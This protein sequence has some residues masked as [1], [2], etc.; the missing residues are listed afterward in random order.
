MHSANLRVLQFCHGY[1]GP[2]LDCARQY[3]SLFKGTPYKVTTVFLTGLADADVAAA[4]ESDEVL[5]LEQTSR[6]IRTLKLKAIREL[7]SIARTRDF[8]FCIAHRF[9]PIWIAML[10]TRMPV[11]GVHHGYGDYRRLGRKLF[12][13]LF[14]GRLRLLGV[15]N[16]VREDIRSSLPNWPAHHIE[17][18]YNRVDIEP[19]RRSQLTRQAARQALHLSPHAWIVGNAGRLH[20][21]K[22]QATLL[23]GFAHALPSLPAQAQ[24][25]ILGQ[26]RLEEALK[27]LALELGIAD[28]V[29]FL[30]QV[31]E[32]RRYFRAFDVF[33][34]SSD[35]E[36]F[37]MVLLE[38]M[39]AG[40]PLI[41]TGT[42]G[43]GEIVEGLGMLFSIGDDEALG[44][45]LVHLSQ[46]DSQQVET[47]VRLM[48]ER[49]QVQFSDV[50]GRREFWNLS[51]VKEL[52]R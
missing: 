6:E 23:R 8:H 43:A 50:A 33:A 29:L 12:A 20:S 4:C 17:T 7:A 36:P 46:L 5:F 22:D 39:A 45:G 31:A 19:L 11:I 51:M 16:S 15:S 48:D 49:L 32:A 21:D 40:L 18:L 47:C 37:G 27:A 34:L 28:R 44:R 25:V 24:L 30:G 52:A 9:K 41:S 14:D 2:F 1:D 13:R 10:A 38:A 26:G 3:A 42:G 35:N